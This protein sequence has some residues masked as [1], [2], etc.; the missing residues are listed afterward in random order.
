MTVFEQV[1]PVPQGNPLLLRHCTAEQAHC[2]WIWTGLQPTMVQL[3]M[4]PVLVQVT[5]TEV[6]LPLSSTPAD[7]CVTERPDAS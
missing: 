5:S 4:Q 1:A 3:E 7:S 2:P 6:E